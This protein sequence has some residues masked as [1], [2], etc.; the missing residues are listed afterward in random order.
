MQLPKQAWKKPVLARGDSSALSHEFVNKLRA[1]GI[2]FSIGF[3]LTEE[4]RGAVLSV[5]ERSWK[6][7]LDEDG[8]PREDAAVC[9]LK[10]LDLSNW[11]A[12]TRAICRREQPHPGAQLTFTD[13]Q[14]YRF[15][16]FITDQDGDDLLELE[17]RHRAHARVEDRIRCAKETGLTNFP[18]HNFLANQVWLELV[19][20]AQDLIAFF[21][22]LCLRGEA[23]RWEPK[24]L[25]Y[26]LFHT[27][28]RIIRSGR[29]CYLRLQR[30][31]PW[32]RMLVDAFRRME[33]LAPAA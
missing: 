28:G 27:A 16:V 6:P 10:T 1:F 12:G 4:V 2:Q 26:R 7:L 14:G 13:E 11:P 18:F 8:D 29:S 21:Q 20:M 5:P 3:D 15:Q 30:A 33:R 23:Q 22:H 24:K 9:R 32:A 19:L 31:W 17:A 25:R